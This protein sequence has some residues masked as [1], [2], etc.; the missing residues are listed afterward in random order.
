[1][2]N[3]LAQGVDGLPL[4]MQGMTPLSQAYAAAAPAPALAGTPAAA[5]AAAPFRALQPSAATATSAGMGAP[6]QGAHL[7]SIQGAPALQEATGLYEAYGAAGAC[8]G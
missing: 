7:V 4:A 3:G 5:T 2:G 8:R 6:M 1:M